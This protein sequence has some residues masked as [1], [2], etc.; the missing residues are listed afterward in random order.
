MDAFSFFPDPDG[1]LREAHRV[2]RPGGRAVLMIGA[3]MPEGSAP[4][5][6][7]GHVSRNEDDARRMVEA[8]GFDVSM[9]YRPMGGAN[10]LANLICRRMF[11]TEQVRL[12]T[13]RPYPPRPVVTFSST[14]RGR[15]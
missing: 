7:L 1:F 3:Q 11:G 9:A 4:R 14:N 2:L 10:P 12:V 13:D 5:T 6:A 15:A 8:A